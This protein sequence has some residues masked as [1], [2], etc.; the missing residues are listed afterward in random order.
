[1]KVGVGMREISTTGQERWSE[2]KRQ[3][4]GAIQDRKSDPQN[5]PQLVSQKVA[6]R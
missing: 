2:K 1:M 6:P 3:T 5:H 4:E